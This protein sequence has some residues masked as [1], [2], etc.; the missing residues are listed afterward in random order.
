MGDKLEGWDN[1]LCPEANHLIRKM[2]ENDE[3]RRPRPTAA[4]A[5]S[6]P[7]FWTKRKKIDLL[8]AVGNQK[9]EFTCPRAK[10]LFPLSAVETDLETSY[11]TL[12]KYV[13]KWDDPKYLHMPV[14]YSEMTKKRSPYDTF[15]LV[16]LVR[17][18]RNA[19][20]L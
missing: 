20:A 16:E 6:H 19:Y 10:R 18:I 2:L 4:E 12:V 5:A 17:F 11:S 8:I 3:G 7:L 13:M 9:P 1:S 14:I 15:S